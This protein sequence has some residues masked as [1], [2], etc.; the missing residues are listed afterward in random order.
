MD[1]LCA[2]I[3]CHTLSSLCLLSPSPVEGPSTRARILPCSLLRPQH[4]EHSRCSETP[5]PRCCG[6]TSPSVLCQGTVSWPLTSCPFLPGSL[7]AHLPSVFGHL[8]R[9]VWSP[10]ATRSPPQRLPA[11]P[12]SPWHISARL[13]RHALCKQIIEK[14]TPE[15]TCGWLIYHTP[16]LPR[17]F[18]WKLKNASPYEPRAA[19]L[20][21]QPCRP[22]WLPGCLGLCV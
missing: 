22:S 15:E 21:P 2:Y 19:F 8:V 18:Y 17:G 14:I 4:L 13:G 20:L 12:V 16:S 10:P 3:T 6:Y 9:G 11:K 5:F 1:D 7:T